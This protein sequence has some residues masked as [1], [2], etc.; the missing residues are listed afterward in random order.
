[1]GDS[2][3]QLSDIGQN[4]LG[5]FASRKPRQDPRQ[6]TMVDPFQN[7]KGQQGVVEGLLMDRTG[8]FSPSNP[9]VGPRPEQSR[10][11]AALERYQ[12]QAEPLYGA[13]VRTLQDTAEGKYLDVAGRPEWQRLASSR[14]DIARD[15]FSDAMSD[16]NARAAARGNFD[17]SARE[18]QLGQQARR[19]GGEAAHDIAQAGW[20]QY[21]N[22][23]GLQQGASQFGAQLA[24]GLAGQVFGAGEQ[25]RSAQQAGNTAQLQAQLQAMGIDQ[26]NIQNILRYMQLASG[27]VLPSVVSGS[28]LDTN[29]K[30]LQT[31]SSAFG[32]IMGGMGGS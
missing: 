28:P 2:G 8:G 5:P 1:M 16:T 9:Y 32:N 25:L 18:Y 19:V 22:E 17:S 27:Q 26:G 3:S 4:F 31:E 15:L 12:G 29:L 23:R 6:Y 14:Q 30:K 20:T 13:G 10:S 11:L 21:G 24:P 7:L